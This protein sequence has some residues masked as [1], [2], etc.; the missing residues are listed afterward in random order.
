[1]SKRIRLIVAAVL[2]VGWLGWLGATALTKSH[3]PIISRAQA[4]GATVVVVADL[5]TGEDGRVV[6]LIRQVPQQGAFPLALSEKADRPALVVKVLQSLKDGPAPEA[7][8]G[9]ANLP[10]C[11][12]YAGPG[13]YLLLLNKDAASHFE[14]N[15]DAYLLAERPRL[16]GTDPSAVGLPV[17]Y[18][19]SDKTEAD[20]LDQVKKLFP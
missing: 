10:D 17:I 4:A 14:G 13:R 11:V 16:P 8:I 15:R 3:A 9:V 6:H 19:W 1:M 7:Q 5:T 20:L 12:G 18:P 2:F